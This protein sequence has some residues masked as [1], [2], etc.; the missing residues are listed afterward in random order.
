MNSF[1]FNNTIETVNNYISKLTT[2]TESII[3]GNKS[4]INFLIDSYESLLS[5]N[6]IAMSDE[7]FF[8][9][10]LNKIFYQLNIPSVEFFKDTLH[11]VFLNSDNFIFF[12]NFSILNILSV[13]LISTFISTLLID[14]SNIFGYVFVLFFQKNNLFMFFSNSIFF[15]SDFLFFF[16]IGIVIMEIY[17]FFFIFLNLLNKLNNFLIT[18]KFYDNFINFFKYNNLSFIEISIT[19]TL[20]LPLYVFDIFLSFSEDDCA[21]TIFFL[22]LFFIVI[23]FFFISLGMDIQYIYSMSNVN[24]GDV[25]IR[26]IFSDILNNFLS[27]LRIFLC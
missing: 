14:F 5:T 18:T 1:L 3:Y 20:F 24:S 2:Q 9:Y 17:F 16:D 27:I 19:C 8:I 12:N 23:L 15:F 10:Y 7:N 25:T 22:I 4:V 21:D 6:S 13:G 26:L 11:D